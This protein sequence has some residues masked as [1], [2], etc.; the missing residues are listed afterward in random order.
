[1]SEDRRISPAL[2]FVVSIA[3]GAAMVYFGARLIDTSLW[4]FD[5][6]GPTAASVGLGAVGVVLVVLPVLVLVGQLRAWLSR[7]SGRR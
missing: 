1:V 7:S 5:N 3:L 6:D 4:L 2:G